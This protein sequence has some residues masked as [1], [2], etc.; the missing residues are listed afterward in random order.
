MTDESLSSILRRIQAR[1]EAR[2]QAGDAAASRTQDKVPTPSADGRDDA[3]EV[4]AGRGW[5]TPHVDAGHPDFGQVFPCRCQQRRLSEGQSGRLLRYSNLGR[6]SRYSFA[7][8]SEDKVAGGE[9]DL[10]LFKEACRAAVD[11]AGEPKDW[12]TLTGPP[13]SGKTHLAAA[14]ANSLMEAE[15]PVLFIS[16]PDLLDQLRSGYAPSNELGYSEIY[17]HVAEAPILILDALGTQYA[18]PWAEEK[19]RQIVSHRFDAELPTVFTTASNLSELD[20][21]IRVR[22]EH[23]ESARIVSTA[24]SSPAQISAGPSG[25]PHSSMLARM[26]F[27]SFSIGGNHTDNAGKDSLKF[28]AQ[29]ARNFAANP[30]VWLLLYGATGVGK[31]HLA[32]AITGRLLDARHRP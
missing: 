5:Y 29:A 24:T 32:V 6:L 7:S 19:L 23:S 11:F 28:A 31:T 10:S 13:G 14:I 22:L 26:T 12:L 4:C 16:V 2:S 17:R 8:I 21:H 18:T 25:L 30:V 9:A 27:E 20:P 3:C 1:R 15:R